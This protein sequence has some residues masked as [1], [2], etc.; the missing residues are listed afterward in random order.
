MFDYFPTYTGTVESV[1][2]AQAQIPSVVAQANRESNAWQ[3]LIYLNSQT[4]KESNA[5][6]TAVRVRIGTR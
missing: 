6:P 1:R 3:S 4:S 5:T 2:S